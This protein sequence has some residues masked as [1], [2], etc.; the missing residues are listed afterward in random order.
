MRFLIEKGADL[1]ARDPRNNDTALQLACYSGDKRTT[2]NLIECGADLN[3]P[4]G[5]YGCAFHI[6]CEKRDLD[7]IEFMYV[8]GADIKAFG[9]SVRKCT[10]S[11]LRIW[12]SHGNYLASY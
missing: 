5:R 6:A 10:T 3:A 2:K 8:Q 12:T 11:C 7:L 1:H 4:G 9:G